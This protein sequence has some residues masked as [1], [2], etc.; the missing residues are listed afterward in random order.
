MQCP[1]NAQSLGSDVGSDTKP[2]K[3][4]NGQAVAV[5]NTL[6]DTTSNQVI[7][8]YKTF[9]T[10]IKTR[11]ANAIGTA[12]YP[13]SVVQNDKNDAFL[14]GMRCAV[15]TNGKVDPYITARN[16]DGTTRDIAIT[17][18]AVLRQIG[19]QG[20]VATDNTT[21]YLQVVIIGK[22]ATIKGCLVTKNSDTYNRFSI[23][24]ELANLCYTLAP[25]SESIYGSAWL[26]FYD[27]QYGFYSKCTT[28][29]YLR[30]GRIYQ[31]H[32]FG[33]LGQAGGFIFDI[34]VPLV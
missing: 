33:D 15:A 9:A 10:N 2:I 20:A 6:V 26:N 8:G 5:T 1:T 7:G 3:I 22:S 12:D 31:N 14:Y 4:V 16:A 19:F 11:S 28:D 32:G 29:G 27:I 17:G 30:V 23:K 25:L 34:T 24:N 21:G 18:S 13:Y